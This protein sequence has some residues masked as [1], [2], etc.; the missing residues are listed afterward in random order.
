[1][2]HI[3]ISLEAASLLLRVCVLKIGIAGQIRDVLTQNLSALAFVYKD[4]AIYI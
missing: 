1:M 4:H 2:A 3:I